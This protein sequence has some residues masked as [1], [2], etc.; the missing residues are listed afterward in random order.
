M[1]ASHIGSTVPA[2]K[3]ILSMTLHRVPEYIQSRSDFW[4]ADP[5]F[6]RRA[7]KDQVDRVAKV[8]ARQ[9]KPCKTRSVNCEPGIISTDCSGNVHGVL[10]TQWTGWS[11]TVRIPAVN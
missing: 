10:Q 3:K 5:L 4:Q 1:A 6:R 9:K 8:L 7:P 11:S 2:A